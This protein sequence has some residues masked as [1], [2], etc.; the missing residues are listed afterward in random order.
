MMSIDRKDVVVD[1]NAID[2]TADPQYQSPAMR[3][4]T[5][6][7]P[8]TSTS[9]TAS[10]IVGVGDDSLEHRPIRTSR[11]LFYSSPSSKRQKKQEET[12]EKQLF[13]PHG[14]MWKESEQEALY[15]AASSILE[16][17]AT[18]PLPHDE[19]EHK[20]EEQEK[21]E[22]DDDEGKI[23][24]YTLKAEMHRLRNKHVF[25]NIEVV[26]GFEKILTSVKTEFPVP[27]HTEFAFVES[28]SNAIKHMFQTMHE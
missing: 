24:T 13:G 9:N 11:S 7:Y 12:I 14:L 21:Y 19:D 27:D 25:M 28:V 18:L 3:K 22:E 4:R 15:P 26:S 10:P 16:R 20:E 23:V 2:Q 8:L 5:I 1:E 6:E 17:C